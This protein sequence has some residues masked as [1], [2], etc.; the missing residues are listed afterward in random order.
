GILEL[1]IAIFKA[2]RHIRGDGGFKTAANGE[3]V[4]VPFQERGALAI[5]GCLD[6]EVLPAVAAENVSE[7]GFIHLHA[8]AGQDIEAVVRSGVDVDRRSAKVKTELTLA[9]AVMGIDHD[10]GNEAAE[11]VVVTGIDFTANAFTAHTIKRITASRK[12]GDVRTCRPGH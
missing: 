4:D 2:D 12:F 11:V 6:L 8:G 9:I 7:G 1:G 10:T 5:T 3:A